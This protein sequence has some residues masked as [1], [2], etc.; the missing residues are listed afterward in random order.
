MVDK[1]NPVT[2]ALVESQARYKLAEAQFRAAERMEVA[3]YAALSDRVL[4]DMNDAQLLECARQIEAQTRTFELA[5]ALDE[6]AG[7]MV[8]R[9]R[10]FIEDNPNRVRVFRDPRHMRELFKWW[11]RVPQVKSRFLEVCA[12][13]DPSAE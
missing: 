4:A 12:N 8:A 13:L 10:E 11:N 5:R 9:V 6:A 1:W 7:E 3:M 2:R